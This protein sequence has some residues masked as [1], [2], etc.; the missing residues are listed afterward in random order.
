MEFRIENIDEKIL[1]G[2]NEDMSYMDNKTAILWKKF[3]PKRSMIANRVDTN[4]YSLQV[5]N[6]VFDYSTFNL[7]MDFRKWALVEVSASDDVPEVMETL[8]S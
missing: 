7:A 3:M 8:Y 4:Y 5:Y 6:E 2:M 1:I